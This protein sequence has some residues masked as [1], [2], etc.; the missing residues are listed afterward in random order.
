MKKSTEST[1]EKHLGT[2]VSKIVLSAMVVFLLFVFI[3]AL[4]YTYYNDGAQTLVDLMNNA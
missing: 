3:A 4:F 1:G 2:A